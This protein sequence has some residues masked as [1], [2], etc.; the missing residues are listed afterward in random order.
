MYKRQGQ[1]NEY[2]LTVFVKEQEEEELFRKFTETHYQRGY[3]LQQIKRLLEKSGLVFMDALDADTLDEV[4]DTSAVSY[5][6]LDVYKRQA[7][8]PARSSSA[9]V[10]DTCGF[11]KDSYYFYPVSYTHLDVYKRQIYILTKKK[12]GE[13][14]GFFFYVLLFSE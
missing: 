7:H 8:W 2:D 12:P 4:T 5:T 6:H 1:I 3:T 9:G 14:T 10:L 13:W 11:E